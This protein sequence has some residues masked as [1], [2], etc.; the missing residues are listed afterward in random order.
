MKPEP[1]YDAVIFTSRLSDDTEGDDDMAARMEALVAGRTESR[2]TQPRWS[3]VLAPRSI[4]VESGVRG[5]EG[6]G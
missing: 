6:Y 3:D 5:D 2:A 4:T 1:P